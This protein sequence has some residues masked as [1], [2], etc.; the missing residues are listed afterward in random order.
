MSADFAS[1]KFKKSK[2]ATQYMRFLRKK[3]EKPLCKYENHKT[4]YG[5]VWHFLAHEDSVESFLVDAVLVVL[6][7]YYI[8]Y[9]ALGLAF[10]TNYP[11][12]AVVSDSMD[13]HR[14]SFD[15]W[16]GSSGRNYEKYDITEADFVT[17]P[18]KNGFVK[19]DVLVVKGVPLDKL[20]I[21]DVIVYRTPSRKDPIIHRLVAVNRTDGTYTVETKGDA[22]SGQLDFEKSIKKEQISGKAIL[23]VPKIGWVKVGFVEL[24][25]KLFK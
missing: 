25:H 16:W 21:G 6:I 20:E 19:G 17:F 23:L 7:G 22:N 2:L 1:S 24:W 11:V 4:W 18:F 14:A 10:G 9:P 13:H 8:I 15:Q 12:V 3:K 5:K